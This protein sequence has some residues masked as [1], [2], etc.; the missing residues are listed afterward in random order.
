MPGEDCSYH[1]LITIL[2]RKKCLG[3][4]S[5]LLRQL[6]SGR[7]RIRTQDWLWVSNIVLPLVGKCDVYV[8]YQLMQSL[9]SF[10]PF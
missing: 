1:I 6:G 2:Q 3:R 4:S 10:T 5:D 8:R 7:E 9:S